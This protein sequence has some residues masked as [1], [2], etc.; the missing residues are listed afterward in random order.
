MLFSWCY[1]FSETTDT[2]ARGAHACRRVSPSENDAQAGLSQ[3][4]PCERAYQAITD[5]HL[6]CRRVGGN[7][8]QWL[9]Q[10]NSIADGIGCPVNDL[11][12]PSDDDIHSLLIR[13]HRDRSGRAHGGHRITL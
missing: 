5:T 6:T 11:H 4:E 7:T 3:R 2:A 1:R 13:V 10:G 9:T 12:T 8:P